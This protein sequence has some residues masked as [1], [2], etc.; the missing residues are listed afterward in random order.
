L[1]QSAACG[2]AEF[3]D[4]KTFLM[5]ACGGWSTMSV[6]LGF[7]P[8]TTLVEAARA[9]DA[10][11]EDSFS[12][13]IHKVSDKLSVLASG[14]DVM[15]DQSLNGE[16]LET[17]L[18]LLLVKYPVVFID[19]SHSPQGL[20]NTVISRAHQINVVS[21]SG[22]VSL[23]QGRSLVQEIKDLRGGQSDGIELII[24]MHGM[25]G[26]KDVPKGDI[27]TA[28]DSKVSGVI[29][30]DAKIFQANESASRKIISDKDGA[31]LVKSKLLPIVQKIIAAD[32]SSDDV[33]QKPS[34]GGGL[35][36]G[37]IQKL[38]SK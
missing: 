32:Y 24:N 14:S 4:Q 17:M 6:G 19:L 15:L 31:E 5:D 23:R 20:Q 3:M 7:E 2:V 11:D 12:R 27:E 25:P 38:S 30:Y 18:D 9:A 8:V 10:H 36:G 34:K 37:L 1:C 22:L 26:A 21:S 35:L 13:M 28:M 29:P 16:Q 33:E